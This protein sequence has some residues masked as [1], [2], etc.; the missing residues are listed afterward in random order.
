MINKHFTETD[1]EFLK[2]NYLAM[3]DEELAE[4]FNKTKKSIEA[5]RQRLGLFRL[6]MEEANTIKDEKWLPVVGFE[7]KYQVSNKGRIK[8]KKGLLKLYVNDKGYAYF[9]ASVS[10]NKCKT[11]RINRAVALAFIPNPENKPEVNHIDFNKLNNSVENLEWNTREENMSH[12]S[13][14]FK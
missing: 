8:N 2:T 10:A 11:Y 14:S 7:D 5:K 3:S 13:S 9:S 12:W 1:I 6:I 4:Y